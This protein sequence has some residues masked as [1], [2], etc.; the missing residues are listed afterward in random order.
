MK[1]I[2]KFPIRL[3]DTKNFIPADAVILSVQLRVVPAPDLDE[4]CIWAIRDT[5]KPETFIR[6]IFIYGTGWKLPDD[7]GIHIGTVQ[8]PPYVWHLFEKRIG[9]AK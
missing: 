5:N 8:M 4:I 2:H 6:Q 3:G 9:E 7:P 1:T